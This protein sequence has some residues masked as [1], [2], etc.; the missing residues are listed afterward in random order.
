M[1]NANVSPTDS[2]LTLQNT[3]NQAVD[4]AGWTLRVGSA[5][6]ALPSNAKIGPNDS[7]TIHTGS[8]SSSGKDLYLGSD[9]ATI[10]SAFRP[11][12]TVAIVNQQGSTVTQFAL[13][14]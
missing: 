3:S 11:G 2:T 4:M 12:T 7:M 14:A 1:L 6:V 13:P 8:G 9:A 5:S 10:A